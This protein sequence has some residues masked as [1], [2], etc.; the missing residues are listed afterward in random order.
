MYLTP[1]DLTRVEAH[2]VVSKG[3]LRAEPFAVRTEAERRLAMQI[4]KKVV[5]EFMKVKTEVNETVFSVE[6]YLVTPKQLFDIIRSATQEGVF[7]TL[8]SQRKL[9]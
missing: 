1:D 9:K 5:S 2:A 7:D 8:R 6:F 4:A 3:L